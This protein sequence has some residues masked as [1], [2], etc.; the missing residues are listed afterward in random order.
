MRQPRGNIDRLNGFFHVENSLRPGVTPF[1]ESDICSYRDILFTELKA[2]GLI[3]VLELFHPLGFGL[4]L[5]KL[6]SAAAAHGSNQP[7]ACIKTIK[8]RISRL[9]NKRLNG[10]GSI[11]QDRTKLFP[12]PEALEDRLEVAAYIMARPTI[13]C[14]EAARA[15]GPSSMADAANG[16]PR[17][18]AAIAR[19]FGRA[20]FRKDLLHQLEKQC[21]RIQA[22]CIHPVK[23][24]GRGRPAEWRPACERRG[25]LKAAIPPP[26]PKAYAKERAQAKRR[27][28]RMLERYHAFCE[29]Q[30]LNGIPRGH[31]G[32]TELRKWATRL[33]GEFHRGRVPQWQLDAL[34][35]TSVL[36]PLPR[37]AAAPSAKW[38]RQY[39]ALVRFHQK[40][41]HCRV[42]QSNSPSPTLANWVSAQRV[43]ARKEGLHPEKEAQLDALGFDWGE[44][45]RPEEPWRLPVH[46]L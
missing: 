27:F 5:E 35:S 33:R 40:H 32:A 8:Q 31:P 24:S 42:T 30:G 21:A 44:A 1:T 9:H 18:A 39:A 41:G 28:F 2:A 14:G 23:T 3:P 37:T 36:D 16:D 45:R 26:D 13:E 15:D 29:S 11:W 12:I 4:L 25:H 7:S 38:Q 19:L 22:A 43:L 17:A 10:S 46:L 20:T 34:R 6:P